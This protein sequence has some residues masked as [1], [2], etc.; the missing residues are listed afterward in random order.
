MHLIDDRDVNEL[1]T[2]V[3]DEAQAAHP[4]D[5]RLYIRRGHESRSSEM[6]VRTERPIRHIALVLLKAA[7]ILGC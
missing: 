3:K 6:A 4:V 2:I 5:E 1:A 7:R